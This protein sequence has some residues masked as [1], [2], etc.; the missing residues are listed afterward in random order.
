MLRVTIEL[1]PH[2]DESKAEVVGVATIVNTGEGTAETGSY[3]VKLMKT[4]KFA[5]RPGVWR[6]GRVSGFPRL[7]LGPYDLLYRCLA[8]CVGPRNTRRGG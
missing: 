4:A 2:G 1:L 5:K 7:K 6:E 8:V 3:E